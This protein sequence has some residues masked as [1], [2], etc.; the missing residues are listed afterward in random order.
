ML[1][2]GHIAIVAGDGFGAD[3]YV[4]LSYAMAMEN[5][6]EGLDRFEKV[7]SQIR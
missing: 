4:R 2:E 7:L 1:S 3:E 5:I 6:K